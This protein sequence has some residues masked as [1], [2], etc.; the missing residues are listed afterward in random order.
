MKKRRITA[1]AL[2]L[3]LALVMA[4]SLTPAALASSSSG[5]GNFKKVRDYPGFSDV[6]ASSWY[7]NDV[8]QAYEL[9]LVGGK[10]NN[11]FDPEG[12][13]TVAEALTMAA[14]VH[15][16]YFGNDFEPDSDSTPWYAD[17]VDYMLEAGVIQEG[18]YKDYDAKATRSDLANLF[19]SIPSYEFPR[20]NR[21]AWIS[22]VPTDSEYF[23]Y[24]YLLYSAGVL[25][26]SETGAFQ[27][28]N[29]VT[30]AEAAAIINRVVLPENRVSFSISTNAPG[31]V[32]TGANG[33]FK[34]SI[35]K[36]QGWEIRQNEV[37]EDGNCSFLC[38]KK[39]DGDTATLSMTVLTKASLNWTTLYAV[40]LSTLQTDA[41]KNRGADLGEDD[42]TEGNIRALS[43][44][45][46]NFICD[47][48]D[49]TIFCT[50]NS[51]QI[52]EISLA[53][54]EGCNEDLANEL[55]DIFLTL[56]IAL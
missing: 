4:L 46:A 54:N 23:N 1:R 25:T 15:A 53:Y 37:D 11:K 12:N 48:V 50:E 31:Q 5:M 43:G 24:I 10:P 41:F 30:R 55:L 32:V 52:Y 17:A 22:D 21:I 35:P 28:D 20:I 27:P 49:W 9:G 56:D 8:R 14:R 18:D 2:S 13:L 29:P 45:Y 34:I 44:Y 3:F 40:M 33:N 39:A 16:I 7:A 26:G 36:D 47:K 38:V 42:I 19:Y 51:N 6:P